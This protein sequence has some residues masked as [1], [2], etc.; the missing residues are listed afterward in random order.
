[1]PPQWKKG[2]GGGL[3]DRALRR[4]DTA[5]VICEEVGEDRHSLDRSQTCYNQEQFAPSNNNQANRNLNTEASYT[6]NLF[7]S[8]KHM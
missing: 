3:E 8:A 4:S 5:I 7:H 1:V 6:L 2:R